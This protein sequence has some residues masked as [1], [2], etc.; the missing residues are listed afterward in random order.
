MSD[1]MSQELYK[2]SYVYFIYEPLVPD[3]C[4]KIGESI[5]PEQ[6]RRNLQTGNKRFLQVY[7]IIACPNKIF[8][9]KLEELLHQRYA[10]RMIQG[11][12]YDVSVPE[13]Q[14]ICTVAE[15]IIT[16][17]LPLEIW[18]DVWAAFYPIVVPLAPSAP[19]KILPTLVRYQI[20]HLPISENCESVKN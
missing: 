5:N 8:A 9:Q 17:N 13:V 4:F 14:K 3:Q 16:N 20:P 6:R 2:P 12:W 10:N 7:R 18:T 1:E 15:T 19:L 11:E